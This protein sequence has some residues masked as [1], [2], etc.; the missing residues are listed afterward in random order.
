MSCLKNVEI[1]GIM[2]KM[3]NCLYF[4][5]FVFWHNSWASLFGSV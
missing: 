3:L 2:K 1:F 5:T 4:Q